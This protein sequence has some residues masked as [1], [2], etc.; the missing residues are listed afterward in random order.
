MTL[1]AIQDQNSHDVLQPASTQTSPKVNQLKQTITDQ[2]LITTFSQ[3]LD[4]A[5]HG[6]TAVNT[7]GVTQGVTCLV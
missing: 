4:R 3:W 5:N 7:Q 1:F 6:V 2:S